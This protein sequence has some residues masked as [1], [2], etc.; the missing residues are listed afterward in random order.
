MKT[1]SRRVV[2]T[3]MG[4]I[5]CLGLSRA[6]VQS[7]LHEGRSGIHF[8]PERKKMGFQSALSGVIKDFKPESV[9]NRKWRKSLPEFGIWA[10]AAIEQAL[11]Q[12]G[13]D[14][15]SLSGAQLTGL[16]FGNDSSAVTAVEIG[17]AHV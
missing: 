17:R 16:I 9:L 4:I 1:G 12:A 8:L 14:P 10:W 13:I 5:S 7:A 6:E 15:S 2:I 3:G 11:S